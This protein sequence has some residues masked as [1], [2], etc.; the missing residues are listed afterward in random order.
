MSYT[1]HEV[2]SQQP[3]LGGDTFPGRC[4][5]PLGSCWVQSGVLFIHH[6]LGQWLGP[7][8]D[9]LPEQ[10]TNKDSFRSKRQGMAR[11]TRCWLL[12][13]PPLQ[14]RRAAEDEE[15]AVPWQ[16]AR[17]QKLL[18]PPDKPM[19]LQQHGLGS[20]LP[21]ISEEK[22]KCSEGEAMLSRT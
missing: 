8:R 3:D 1:G 18:V 19:S 4:F 12:Q 6:L 7:L 16:E 22:L 13:S 11:H 14:P 15:L 20:Q 21:S 17:R 5:V 10:R 9:G 2:V